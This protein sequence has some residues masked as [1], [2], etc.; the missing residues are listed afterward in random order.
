MASDKNLVM[1]HRIEDELR[2]KLAIAETER[3]ALRAKLAA[4]VEAGNRI[5]AYGNVYR[6]KE[7]EVSPYE[8]LKA[9]IEAAEGGAND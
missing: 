3:A 6:Y 1:H 5:L 2:G 8:Q 9:A 4:L 7:T